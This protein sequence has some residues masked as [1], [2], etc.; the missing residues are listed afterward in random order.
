MKLYPAIVTVHLLGGQLLEHEDATSGW[1]TVAQVAQYVQGGLERALDIAE[2]GSY[3]RR[4]LTALSPQQ[5]QTHFTEVA[6]GE[7]QVRSKLRDMITFAQMN[8]A[9]MVYMGRFDCI[10]CMDVLPHFSTAQ[11]IALTQR[12]HLYLEPGGYLL[13]GDGEKLQTADVA[14]QS[15]THKSFTLYRKP[16]AA[17]ANAGKRF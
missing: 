15:Q 9:Q 1:E 4:D 5:I 16:L 13:L 14:F 11:R 8:L 3:S 7:Y 2:R 17:A 6:N 10:F 12:L